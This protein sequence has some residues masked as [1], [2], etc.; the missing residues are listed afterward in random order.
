MVRQ[1][2]KNKFNLKLVIMLHGQ[3]MATLRDQNIVYKVVESLYCA[4]KTNVVC[5]STILKQKFLKIK[6]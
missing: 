2:P 1:C 3:M 4:P 5:V 6:L